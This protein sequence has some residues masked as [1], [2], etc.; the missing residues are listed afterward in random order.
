MT[1]ADLHKLSLDELSDLR[2]AVNRYMETWWGFSRE[3]RARQTPEWVAAAVWRLE[4]QTEPC[5]ECGEDYLRADLHFGGHIFCPK[6]RE[7]E[8]GRS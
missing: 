6:C 1:E 8:K 7:T 4:G 2:T 3:S 5:C